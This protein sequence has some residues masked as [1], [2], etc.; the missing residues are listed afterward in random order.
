ML[1]CACA[2]KPGIDHFNALSMELLQK[3][4]GFVEMRTSNRCCSFLRFLS[5]KVWK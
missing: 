2:P 1:V 5:E 3:I 4:F